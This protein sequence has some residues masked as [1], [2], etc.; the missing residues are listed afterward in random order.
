MLRHMIQIQNK[1]KIKNIQKL[2][3]KYFNF[4][5]SKNT[6]DYEPKNPNFSAWGFYY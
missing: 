3:Y 2:E 6:Y 4:K 5:M 1:E